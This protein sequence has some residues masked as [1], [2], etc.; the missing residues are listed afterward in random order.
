VLSQLYADAMMFPALF[1]RSQ[2]PQPLVGVD[3]QYHV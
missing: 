3:W 2:Q 1:F